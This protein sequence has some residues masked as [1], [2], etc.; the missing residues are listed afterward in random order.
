MCN[1]N[2]ENSLRWT[3]CK[4]AIISA[5]TLEPKV[6]VIEKWKSEKAKFTLYTLKY[7]YDFISVMGLQR[8][9]STNKR[10]FRWP[11]LVETK[12]LSLFLTRSISLAL[13][14]IYPSTKMVT[15]RKSL[16]QISSHAFDYPYVNNV[17]NKEILQQCFATQLVS[18]RVCAP[19]LTIPLTHI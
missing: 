2:I 1:L 4:A 13:M 8:R 15:W 11:I 17:S 6:A 18:E 10:T 9:F 14:F 7:F 19:I 12:I 5:R 16:A 3:Q